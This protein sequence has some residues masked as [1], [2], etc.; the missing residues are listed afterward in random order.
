MRV[1]VVGATGFLGRHAARALE[2]AGHQ[3]LGTCRAGGPGLVSYQLGDPLATAVLE[4]GPEVVVDL[5]WEGIPDF[6]PQ[7]CEANVAGQAALFDEIATLSSVR[8]LVVAGSCREYGDAVG[9]SSGRAT[10][11]DDFGRAKDEVHRM[12]AKCCRD[13]RAALTWLRIFY[14]YGPGQRSGS[15]LPMVLEDLLAGVE[16]RVR[17][18]SASHDFIEVSDV[19]AAIL[20]S[21]ESTGSHDVVD[22]GS[23]SP[24]T[25]T[26]LVDIAR[27]TL[28]GTGQ[29]NTSERYDAGLGRAI[30]AD[31]DRSEQILGWRP[32]VPIET[33]IQRMVDARSGQA[34]RLVGDNVDESG[35]T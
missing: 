32:V 11:V 6:S 9:L 10:P 18:W 8:R 23:G 5:G 17:D 27:R 1:L 33:G 2:V 34:A 13:T 31:V 4:F 3:V 15:L 7:R 30:L 12:A 21:T 26:N 35:S 28:E 14:V 22:L 29:S 16:P 24:L 20:A 25:V 19:A